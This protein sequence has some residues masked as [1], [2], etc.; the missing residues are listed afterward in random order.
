MSL[1]GRVRAL[2]TRARDAAAKD[3]S[4]SL[5]DTV[6]LVRRYLVQE[7]LGSLKS[8]GRTLALGAA[9][10][11]VAGIGAIF[12]LLGV[13]RLL[14]T[15]TGGAFAGNWSFAPYLL[16]A[17]VGLGGLGATALVA[18]RAVRALRSDGAR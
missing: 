12:A 18:V 14:E 13:L 10:A 17:V 8:L 16:T 9:G 4:A 11:L 1:G 2:A 15:E 3:A 7:T 6:D 5:S